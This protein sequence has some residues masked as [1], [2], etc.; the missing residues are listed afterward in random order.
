M[1]TRKLSNLNWVIFLSVSVIK[2]GG[3]EGMCGQRLTKH[4]RVDRWSEA[5]KETNGVFQLFPQ[6]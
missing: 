5:E 2:Q 1:V 4:R 3:A 6:R